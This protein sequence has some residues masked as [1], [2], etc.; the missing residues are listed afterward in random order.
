[1]SEFVIGLDPSLTC[2][3]L[4]WQLDGKLEYRLVTSEPNGRSVTQRLDRYAKLLR[5]IVY[6]IPQQQEP[7]RVFIEH[8]SSHVLGA[9]AVDLPEF[10]G[11]L[12]DTLRT[13]GY[14][15]TE[16]APTSLKKFATGKGNSDKIEMAVTLSRCF[17]VAWASHDAYDALGLWWWGMCVTGQMKPLQRQ[18]EALQPK[19]KKPRKK[20]G[21]Q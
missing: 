7:V 9:A 18:L 1:M 5:D 11:L 3:A 19:E 15:I 21:Q 10:G 17:D 2:T 4:A 13:E 12:R 16:V 8:Y 20:R 6:A 14:G